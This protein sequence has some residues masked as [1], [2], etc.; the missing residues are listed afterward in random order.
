MALGRFPVKVY[1]EILRTVLITAVPIGV[2]I[3]F[4]AEALLG[5]LSFK[6]VLYAGGIGLFFLVLAQT[7][8]N[9]ALRN[10]TSNSV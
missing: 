9:S 8:W 3:S 4:P 7:L 10:Y 1:T 5:V 2:M 6:G